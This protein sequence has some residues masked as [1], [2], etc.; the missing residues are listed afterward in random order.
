MKKRFA[1][2]VLASLFLCR[3]YGEGA[4][5]FIVGPPGLRV[6]QEDG[7]LAGAG[8]YCEVF[9]GASPNDLVD[10]GV[11]YEFSNGK[12]PGRLVSIP[13][14]SEGSTGYLSFVA[15]DSRYGSQL[16]DVP[17]FLRINSLISTNYLWDIAR[18]VHSVAYFSG[19]G[20]IPTAVP[21]PSECL[22]L[23]G[24]LLLGVLI[25]RMGSRSSTRFH[26]GS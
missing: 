19:P 22:L 21:E 4:V 8:I 15:W 26:P 9:A 6:G 25:R 12:I 11:K 23:G 5:L 10:L 16:S 13:F 17:P 2:G 20:V 24:S 3:A 7:P 14:L 18:D 1:C